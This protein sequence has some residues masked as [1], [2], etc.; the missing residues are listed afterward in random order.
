M[1]LLNASLLVQGYEDENMARGATAMDSTMDSDLQLVN[2]YEDM[3]MARSVTP[4]QVVH[5][6]KTKRCRVPT[7]R[8]FSKTLSLPTERRIIVA[9][10]PRH[11][12]CEMKA[13]CSDEH[14]RKLL[15]KESCLAFE[16]LQEDCYVREITGPFTMDFSESLDE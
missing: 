4:S 9:A 14:L 3:A 16:K 8:T 12:V 2:G 6:T 13:G 10:P 11:D 15:H 5:E 7:K 1:D